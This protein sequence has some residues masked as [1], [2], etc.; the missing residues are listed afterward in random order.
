[1]DELCMRYDA[2]LLLGYLLHTG[3]MH[4]RPGPYPV[5]PEKMIVQRD[6]ANEWREDQVD[7]FRRERTVR[8]NRQL[9][10]WLVENI[11]DIHSSSSPRGSLAR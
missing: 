11:Q 1:M 7:M 3:D 2:C 9:I 4:R 10:Q 5:Q 6:C 8:Q